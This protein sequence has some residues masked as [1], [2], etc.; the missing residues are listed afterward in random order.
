[1]GFSAQ[2]PL[3]CFA[4]SPTRIAKCTVVPFKAN[5]SVWWKKE[6]KEEEKSEP[7]YLAVKMTPEG[8]NFSIHCAMLMS[9]KRGASAKGDFSLDHVATVLLNR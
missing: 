3:R 9:A 1:M 4:S 6:A 5:Q 8:V 2:R 7:K